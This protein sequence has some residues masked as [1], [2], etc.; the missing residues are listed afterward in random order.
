MASKKTKSNKGKKSKPNLQHWLTQKLRR[1]SYQWGP[2]K[3]AIKKGRVSRGKYKCS[4]CEGTHFGPSDIQLDH[5]IPVIDPHT[6]FTTWD[7]YI[8]RL[9]CNEDGFSV[10][11]KPCH[12]AKTFRENVVRRAVKQDNQEDDI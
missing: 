1:L 4:S 8:D 9:F 6:G 5:T 7:N 12:E 11:C 2:R 10:M 3:E